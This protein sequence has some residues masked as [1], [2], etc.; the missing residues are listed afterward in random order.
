MRLYPFVSGRNANR[1]RPDRHRSA[2]RLRAS[3]SG[4]HG[5]SRRGTIAE[6]I[7]AGETVPE[8]A[9]D[10]GLELHGNR[11]GRDLRAGRLNLV[12][13]TD[14]DLGTGFPDI[15]AAAGLDVERHRDHFPHDCSDVDWLRTIGSRGSGCRKPRST[16]PIQTERA[17]RGRSTSRDAARRRRQD[18][19]SSTRPAFRRHSPENHHLSRAT[20]A[21][22]D[23]EGLSTVTRRTGQ[24]S[25]CARHRRAVVSKAGQTAR[26]AIDL[27]P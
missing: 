11:A 7:D 16:H 18:A 19:V 22:A 12:F 8:L 14:R 3:R 23:R 2:D 17:R 13:F 5:A 4:A 26:S 20:H 15:L 27:T 25:R 24:K 10:Y 9:S 1:E 6:R 21:A